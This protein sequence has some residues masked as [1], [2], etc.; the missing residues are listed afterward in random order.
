VGISSVRPDISYQIF[1]Q[2]TGDLRKSGV[3][4]PRN[5]EDL[6]SVRGPFVVK[7]NAIEFLHI[8]IDNISYVIPPDRSGFDPAYFPDPETTPPA[9]VPSN[10]PN[11][12]KTAPVVGKSKGTSKDR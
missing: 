9:V 6:C 7:S 11:T 4:A 10:K 8:R 12:S 5:G 2:S 3:L 1:E